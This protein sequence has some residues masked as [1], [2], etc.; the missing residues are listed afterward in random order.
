MKE[1]R[2]ER[3]GEVTIH[4][5]PDQKETALD[6]LAALLL[7]L[8]FKE[9]DALRSYD[10]SVMRNFVCEERDE[11][12]HIDATDYSTWARGWVRTDERN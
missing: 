12:I 11:A 3:C 2:C 9:M 1:L 5:C 10:E 8:G 6:M 4:L 7:K